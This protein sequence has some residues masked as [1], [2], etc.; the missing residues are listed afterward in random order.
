MMRLAT[1]ESRSSTAK[2]VN[3]LIDRKRPVTLNIQTEMVDENKTLAE[4][5]AGNEVASDAEKQR[6][7]YEKRLQELE[8]QLQDAIARNQRDRREDLEDAKAEFE[9]K[10]QRSQEEMQRLQLNQTQLHDEMRLKHEA[11]TKEM[12][13]KNRLELAKLRETH[14]FELKQQ[15]IQLRRQ[16][17]AA[18]DD[19]R[20]CIVM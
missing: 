1:A 17:Y 20:R 13:A 15:K 14:D 2:I 11:E 3:Y 8:Q 6:Q 16:L 5:G 9:A 12:E 19:P 18:V 4:T 7:Y 10:V